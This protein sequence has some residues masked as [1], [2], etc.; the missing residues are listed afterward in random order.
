[1]DQI[2]DL[3]GRAKQ[4]KSEKFEMKKQKALHIISLL[5][6][7]SIEFRRAAYFR[8][9]VYFN[10]QIT[11]QHLA[12]TLKMS[13]IV[14]LIAGRTLSTYWKK[15]RNNQANILL[16]T[17]CIN[18]LTRKL[19]YRMLLGSFRRL[20]EV[21]V[22]MRT[23]EVAK[24]RALARLCKTAFLQDKNTLVHAFSVWCRNMNLLIFEEF[25]ALASNADK[26]GAMKAIVKSVNTV[27]VKQLSLA[28]SSWTQFVN[29]DKMSENCK[30]LGVDMLKRAVAGMMVKHLTRAFNAWLDVSRSINRAIQRKR[31]HLR[32]LRRSIIAII[33]KQLSVSFSV[34]VSILRRS[35]SE[36]AKVSHMSACKHLEDANRENNKRNGLKLLRNAFRKL[37]LMQQRR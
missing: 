30:Y 32:L 20:L 34:W 3:K 13:V 24:K 14:V 22:Q 28:F 35:E 11:T 19:Q 5:A 10:Q 18:R 6:D 21:G 23:R 16:K 9:W 1:M 17:S 25:S 8:R 33:H 26:I 27:F 4:L 15:W 37:M 36:R 7:K 31:Q 29:H 2:E 12:F